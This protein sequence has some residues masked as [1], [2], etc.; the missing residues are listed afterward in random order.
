M[1][2]SDKQY[3]SIRRKIIKN[4]EYSL[5]HYIIKVKLL[6]ASYYS[7]CPFCRSVYGKDFCEENHMKERHSFLINNEEMRRK[8]ARALLSNTNGWY[9]LATDC[10]KM[11]A[12]D[13]KWKWRGTFTFDEL[14]TPYLTSTDK[15]NLNSMTIASNCKIQNNC[16]ELNIALTDA[17]IKYQ[18]PK[19]M[20]EEPS[21]NNFIE[22]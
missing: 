8:W 11:K 16:E 3:N 21:K 1:N 10:C 4:L 22:I 5:D 19:Q 20:K 18:P 13:R 12:N 14:P 17:I 15:Y 9:S 7:F 2:S 6:K